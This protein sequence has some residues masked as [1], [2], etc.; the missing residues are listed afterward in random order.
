MSKLSIIIPA[1]NAA[2]HLKACLETIFTG[3]FLHPDF[4]LELVFINDG[5][6]DRT[7]E[8]FKA[9]LKDLKVPPLTPPPSFIARHLP[10]A[11]GVSSAR[12]LGLSLATGDFITFLDSDDHLSRH[13]AS[14]LSPHLHSS[15]DF[16]IFARHFSPPL[17]PARAKIP[18]STYQQL[19]RFALN[20]QPSSYFLANVWSKLYRRDFLASSKITF[21]TDIINGEDMLFNLSVL[22][23]HPTFELVSDSF[24]RYHSNPV[25]ATHSFN[26]RLLYSDRLFHAALAP[27]LTDLKFTPAEI[28]RI[29]HSNL[30]LALYL[31]LRR[32]ATQP[33]PAALAEYNSVDRSFYRLDRI[34]E[35]DKLKHAM[36]HLF[37]QQ[38][39][40]TLYYFTRLQN[41]LSRLKNTKQVFKV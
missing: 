31:L 16:L 39:F 7:A 17:P 9:F 18:R 27:I 40:R 13:W 14:I 22:H 5:S 4:E 33:F 10:V 37:S 3:Y 19:A 26:P 8:I 15:S 30:K 20:Y 11:K 28:C 25:S 38:H 36:F 6:T 29:H 23:A 21:S 32:I 35:S 34:K 2:K 41:F 1:H 24:Y 12:N